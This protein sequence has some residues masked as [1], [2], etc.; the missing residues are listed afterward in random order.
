MNRRNHTKSLTLLNDDSTPWGPTTRSSHPPSSNNFCSMTNQPQSYI[1][2][3]LTEMKK[4]RN[5]FF[6]FVLLKVECSMSQS[7]GTNFVECASWWMAGNWRFIKW[8]N[9]KREL[10]CIIQQVLNDLV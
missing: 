8:I 9:P 3:E 7:N 5:V 6:S 1:P 10:Q 2:L 4:R